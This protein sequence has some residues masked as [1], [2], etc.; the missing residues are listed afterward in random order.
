TR[1]RVGREGIRGAGVVVVVHTR[2]QRRARRALVVEP[3]RVSDLLTRHVLHLRGIV[4]LVR[5][6]PAA[7][8]VVVEFGD[9]LHDVALRRDPDLGEAQPAGVAVVGVADLDVA[10]YGAARRVRTLGDG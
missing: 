8:V 9:T 5:R 6:A 1:V 4:V 7:E 2:V 3:E 10:R